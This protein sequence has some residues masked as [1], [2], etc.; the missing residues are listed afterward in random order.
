VRILP[1]TDE[2]TLWQRVFPLISLDD[3]VFILPPTESIG[4]SY[5]PLGFIPAYQAQQH[6]RVFVAAS[7]RFRSHRRMLALFGPAIERLQYLD[8]ASYDYVID[9]YNNGP[10]FRV[11][12]DEPRHTGAN[13]LANV[14]HPGF[15]SNAVGWLDRGLP[16]FDVYRIHLGLDRLAR[17]SPHPVSQESAL[18][19]TQRFDE[20]GLHAGQTVILYPDVRTVTGVG[21]AEIEQC[22]ARCRAL[23]LDVV[24]DSERDAY[25][26]SAPVIRLPLAEIVP[27]MDRCGHAL[28]VRS[29]MADLSLG[30]TARRGVLYPSM[31]MIQTFSI[32][33]H[34]GAVGEFSIDQAGWVDALTGFISASRRVT[35]LEA[36]A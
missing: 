19:A 18:A 4:D 14:V 22:V 10:Y 3:Q 32:L 25:S 9:V 26:V 35:E 11:N 13:K 1:L 12:Q 7:A 23:G 30:S 20:L 6:R 21:P 31:K 33:E 2:L 27:F 15:G 36:Q 8:D 24:I 5:I 28:I 17:F 34:G 29:G 16:I